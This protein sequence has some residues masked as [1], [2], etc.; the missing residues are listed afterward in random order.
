MKYI[1]DDMLFEINRAIEQLILFLLNYELE[2]TIP[3]EIK[4]RNTI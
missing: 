2:H 3:S 4:N 1:Y